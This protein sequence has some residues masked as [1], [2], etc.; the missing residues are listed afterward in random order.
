MKRSLLSLLCSS[1]ALGA[2]VANAFVVSDIRIDGLQRVSA[3]TV[4]N[5][6]PVSVG[7]DVDG[8]A[9]AGAA[10]ALFRTGYF[11]DIEFGQDGD[12]LVVAVVERP[13]ISTINIKGNK[14]IKSEDLLKGLKQAGLSEGEIFQQATLE[15]IRLELERQ[16]VAQGRYGASIE[17]KV[18]AR[19]RN[20]VSI[21]IDV[22]EGKVAS[23]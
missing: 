6:L 8:K 14:A 3:G 15:A 10:K 22:K 11:S 19:P 20:R 17:T 13:S 9:V 12:V 4:F 5:A 7:D 21:T 16:Y 23:D 18:E 1:L 2:S